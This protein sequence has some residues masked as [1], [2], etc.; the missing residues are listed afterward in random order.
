MHTIK[1]RR[2]IRKSERSKVPGKRRFLQFAQNFF[3]GENYL[4]FAV[5]ALLFGL[6]LAIAAWPIVAAVATINEFL[7]ARSDMKNI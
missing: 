5:E 3:A 6:L 2:T 4:E 1:I 7:R